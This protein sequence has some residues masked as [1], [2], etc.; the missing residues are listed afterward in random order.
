MKELDFDVL[1]V[2]KANLDS[3]E[4]LIRQAVYEALDELPEPDLSEQI[5]ATYWVHAHTLSPS[6]VGKEISYH[7]TSGVRNVPAGSLL[8]ECTGEV[9]DAVNFDSSGKLGLVRV[10]FP[11]KMLLHEDGSLYSTDILHIIAGEGVFGLTENIDIKLCHLA[12]S[13]ETLMRFPGPAYGAIGLRKL[14]N[15]GDDI[16]FGT[17]LKPCTGITPE[18]ESKIVRQA[19]ANSMYLLIKEDENYMPSVPF[20]PLRK[21]LKLALETIQEVA[22]ARQGK[23]LIYAPHISAPPNIIRENVEIC[24]DLGVNGIMFSEQFAGGT[25][26]LVRD[27]TKGLSNPPAIYAHNSGISVRTRH[28]Y[29]EVLDMFCRLDGADFRQTAPLTSGNGLLRPFGLEWRKCEEI[30]GGPLAKHPSTM[31]ARAGGLD[32]GNIIINLLDMEESAGTANYLLLAGSAINSIKNDSGEYDPALGA[33]AMKQALQV[34]R[35]RVFTQISWDHH[36]QL[37]SYAD[38][39]GLDALSRALR[40]RYGI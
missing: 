27:M 1:Q 19:A 22:D 15:F 4:E 7:M 25:L 24:L 18:E 28:I 38:A 34:Y 12:M 21:R 10:G 16:A 33:E 17:I 40:Q 29:R 35:D 30:L 14:A 11:L 9:L 23:G 31:I 13:D 39:N 26:R 32:Q 8:E 5:V 6:Q 2:M 36:A 3:R 37:K 20:S